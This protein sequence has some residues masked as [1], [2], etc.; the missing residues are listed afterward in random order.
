MPS[1]LTESNIEDVTLEI[2]SELGDSVKSA[3]ANII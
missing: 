1:I 2:L 3:S